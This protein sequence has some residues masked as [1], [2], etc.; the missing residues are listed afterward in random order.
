VTG[1]FFRALFWTLAFLNRFSLAGIRLLAALR[2]VFP[3]NTLN[4]LAALRE[5]IFR[6][7]RAARAATTPWRVIIEVNALSET[8]TAAP[9][10]AGSQRATAHRDGRN[11]PRHL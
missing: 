8:L 3:A 9:G 7:G 2:V 1:N 4:L 10:C 5:R 6:C 11:R